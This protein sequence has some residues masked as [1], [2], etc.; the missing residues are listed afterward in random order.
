MCG[1]VASSDNVSGMSRY[2]YNECMVIVASQICVHLQEGG[3]GLA[4][5][6]H[7]GMVQVHAWL[8]W[9]RGGPLSLLGNP[10]LSLIN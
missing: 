4:T 7:G 5:W 2:M 1:C 8:H 9:S 3:F 10:H 6:W